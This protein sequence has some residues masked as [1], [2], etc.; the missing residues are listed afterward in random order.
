MTACALVLLV[1]GV[2]VV[3]QEEGH[4]LDGGYD[5]PWGVL[6]LVQNFV[7][8]VHNIRISGMVRR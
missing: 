4:A 5:R 8:R 7:E 6:L 3:E 1:G 2:H